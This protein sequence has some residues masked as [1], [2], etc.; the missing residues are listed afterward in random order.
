MHLRRGSVASRQIVALGR[1]LWIEGEALA[2]AAVLQGD[3]RIDGV[4]RGDVIALGGDVVLSARAQVDGDVYAV[5]GTIEA[6]D[7]SVIGGR[8]AAYPD[9]PSTALV[10]ME[11]PALGLAPGS[12]PV[13]AAKAAVLCAWLVLA[14]L[15]AALG[16]E[17][18][19]R[20]TGERLRDRPLRSFF[21]GLLAVASTLVG[22]VLFSAFAPAT[23]GLPIAVVG[24]AGLTLAKVWG[25][26]AVFEAV[27][28]AASR[29]MGAGMALPLRLVLGACLL[30]WIKFVPWLG[31][32][33]WSMLTLVAIGATLAEH[34][35]SGGEP[36]D[37]GA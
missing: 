19:L 9:A 18:P 5:G 11:G 2:N 37:A 13:L 20:R 25:T 22:L 8:T 3:A 29:R 35:L 30:G 14:L 34:L 15:A 26:V 33:A 16:C 21:V 7:G 24:I 17:R 23:V 36:A 32:V 12:R 28:S 1:P 31:T 10:L 27:G 4:V 6:A